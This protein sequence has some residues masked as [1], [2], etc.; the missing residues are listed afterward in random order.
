MALFGQDHWLLS[1]RFA[2]D[3]GVRTE[4]QELTETFRLAP[5]AG[6]AWTPLGSRGPV[7]RA[8]AGLF[9]DRVP[10]DVFSFDQYPNRV[11]TT[12]DTLGTLVSGPTT[13]INALGQVD[14]KNPY[15]FHE[16]VPGDFSPRSTTWSFL[17]E[18]NFSSW[19]KV[20][21]AYVQNVSAGLI[22]LNPL[23]PL[24]GN[25][26]GSMLLSGNGQSRYRQFEVSGRIRLETEKRQLFFS[27]VKSRARG[28]LND[29]SGYL[30]SFPA[31]VVRP[32]QFGNL[33]ADLP[34]RFL[35][36]GLVNLPWKFRISPIFEWRTGFPFSLTNA[37]QA[38]VGTPNSQRFPNFLSLDARISKD[39]KVNNKYSVRFS[40]SAN[41]ATNH[42]N[43][44]SV[45]SNTG[46]LLF[47]QFLGQHKRRFMV[48]FDFLL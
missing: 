36:W 1:P 5:R 7:I 31:P 24:A 45:Y 18:Q 19:L 17:A 12:F 33:P 48:D 37:A 16:Q 30:G 42:F 29:F 9:Y 2:I 13:Y 40:V 23:A 44:D 8:G 26:P 28:D 10:L 20:R 39:F 25:L 11:V 4:S 43:P 35:I 41:N 27:Y 14:S 22:I 46:A 32:N 21:A 15:L 38:Y 3:A 47:G 34:D 6:V